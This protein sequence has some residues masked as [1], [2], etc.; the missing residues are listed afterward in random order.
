MARGGARLSPGTFP[1]PPTRCCQHTLLHKKVTRFCLAHHLWTSL[2][3]KDI[4]QTADDLLSKSHN[5]KKQ[6]KNTD[7]QYNVRA[8]SVQYPKTYENVSE[9]S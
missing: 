8:S 5:E 3:V 2:Y 9:Y 4:R 6:Q 7:F 1:D